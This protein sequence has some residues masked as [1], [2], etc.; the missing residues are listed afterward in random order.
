M[1]RHRSIWGWVVSVLAVTGVALVA[2]CGQEPTQVAEI[3]SGGTG[4]RIDSVG[5]INGFGSVIVSGQRYDTTAT[6][7]RVDGMSMALADLRLGMVAGVEGRSLS[8]GLVADRIEALTLARGTVELLG[9]NSLRVNAMNLSTDASTAYG[10]GLSSLA[11]L[12]AGDFVQVWGFAAPGSA[13]RVTRVEKLAAAPTSLIATGAVS[14]LGAGGFQ[15]GGLAVQ[16]SSDQLAGLSN[17]QPVQV[18]GTATAG[19]LL[20]SAVRSL[21]ATGS[22]EGIRLEVEGLITAAAGA[23]RWQVGTQIIDVSRATLSP[24][25]TVLAVGTRIEARGTRS[26]GVLI[27]S[28]VSVEDAETPGEAE[29]VGQIS[30][31]TSLADFVVRGVSIDG[32]SARITNGTAADLAVG[33]NVAVHGRLNGATV[34]AN[35]IEIKR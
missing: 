32:R 23:G 17:G 20:A 31:F 29:L 4:A 3:T 22:A 19:G 27:A 2:S 25:G 15:L 8:T 30:R 35:E 26:N 6:S 16:A 18:R 9:M 11:G 7:I 34:I 5:A 28:T 13:W 33:V 12:V 24:A 21:Q 14:A 1:S 10:G